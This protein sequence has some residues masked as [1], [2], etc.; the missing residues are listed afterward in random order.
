MS[1]FELQRRLLFKIYFEGLGFLS[2][3]Q[4]C[5]GPLFIFSKTV[6]LHATEALGERGAIAPT[7]S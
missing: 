4:P 5:L 3:Q 7:Y 1:F 2:L 6:P